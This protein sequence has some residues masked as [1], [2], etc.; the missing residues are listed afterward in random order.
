MRKVRSFDL[1]IH[2]LTMRRLMMMMI[3]HKNL[4]F[5]LLEGQIRRLKCKS[6]IA[7]K[8]LKKYTD[9]AGFTGYDGHRAAA[10]K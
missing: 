9:D 7:I 1:N 10:M 6:E 5:R 8:I 4:D 2:G 3:G